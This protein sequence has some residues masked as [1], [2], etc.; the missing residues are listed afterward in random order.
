[1]S[2]FRP[3]KSVPAMNDREPRQGERELRELI[4][5][6]RQIEASDASPSSRRACQDLVDK[7]LETSPYRQ[8]ENVRR[9]PSKPVL[10]LRRLARCA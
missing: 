5:K 2:P 3:P 7:L 9:A 1:M 10:W 6:L 8:P 4:E